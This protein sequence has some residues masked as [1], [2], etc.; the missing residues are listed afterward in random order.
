MQAVLASGTFI[1]GPEVQGFA[2]EL[3]EYLG[4]THVVPCANGTDALTLAC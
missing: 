2:T 1:Q 3:S 4:G